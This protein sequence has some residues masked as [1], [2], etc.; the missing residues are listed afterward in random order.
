M[1]A[2]TIQ[3]YGVVQGVGFRP[4]VRNL[5]VS[6]GLTG[7]VRNC[8]PY[9]LIFAQG[10]EEALSLFQGD[11]VRKAPLRAQIRRVKAAKA[12]PE[13]Q[14]DFVIVASEP[15]AGQ[16]EIPPDIGICDTC[17]AELYDPRNRRYLHPFINCTACGPR[18]TILDGLP[19]DR[20]ATSMAPFAMCTG[21]RAEYENPAD[22]RFHAQPV[23]CHDCGPRLWTYPAREGDPVTAARAVLEQGG[24]VA[25]KDIGGFHLCCDARSQTTVERLRRLK[26]RPRKPFAVLARGLE[27]AC[28]ECSLDETAKVLLTGPERPIVLL[29]RLP[30]ALCCGA[31]APGSPTL[32]LMLP[33]APVQM[34][35]FD[36]PDG[37]AASDCLVFTSG[38]AGGAP[39]CRE[40][41]DAIRALSPLCDL[42]LLNDR[43]IRLRADDSV[44][45]V[46]RGRPYMVRR[47]RGYAP[48]PFTLPGTEKRPPAVAVG[49]ELKNAFCLTNAGRLTLSPHIGDLSDE[50]GLM[51]LDEARLRMQRLLGIK[52]RAAVCDLHPAYL[53]VRYAEGLKLPLL[54]VQHH[55]AHIAACLAEN[56]VLDEVIGVAFDGTGFGPDGTVWGGE[57]LRCSLRGF[58]R[59]GSIEPFGLCGG[60][61]ASREGFRPAISLLQHAV[62]GD[63]THLRRLAW[64]LNLC[65]DGRLDAVL[66][67]LKNRVNCVATTS[68]GRLFDAVAAAL[69][70]C[71]VSTF[72]GEA[73]MALE[74]AAQGDG[75]EPPVSVREEGGLLR[76]GTDEL[77]AFLV[78]GRLAGE[79]TGCLAYAF[80]AGL[81]ELVVEACVRLRSR[82]GLNRVALSGGVFQ[83]LL[84][85]EL[86]TRKLAAEGFETLTHSLVPPNDGGI[87]LG[88]AAVYLAGTEL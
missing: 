15:A 64:E 87:A 52:P 29:R 42:I 21:C 37:H 23:C 65:D 69:G 66:F 16:A 48:A 49:G 39:I 83:N 24:V 70:I 58:E 2:L 59:L 67:Q 76:L 14:D 40:N 9:V 4:F 5:A 28:R 72:E 34:L 26:S 68:A 11:L 55:F 54:R 50:R 57:L 31:V 74:T 13:P 19:Y 44:T 7:Y 60:D 35:L 33:A 75:R 12:Q 8:G 27:A 84:L 20:A 56:G 78:K 63:E 41:D 22:R 85:L 10:P 71:E 81:A 25:V 77:F 82:T 61:L 1:Q 6:L 47:S 43:D 18:L 46:H 86:C 79:P 32:G 88:Q 62:G 80:H 45:A 17:A 38:N 36:Y 51:A 30:G 53:S 73:A 3:V